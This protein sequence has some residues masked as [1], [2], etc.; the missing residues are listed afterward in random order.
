MEKGKVKPMPVTAGASDLDFT[1]IKS[2]L[3]EG[4]EVLSVSVSQMMQD[5]EAMK[6]RMK[7]WTS[8]PGVQKK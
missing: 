1:E 5:R 7:R 8:M 6:E 2:G 3:K 4:D